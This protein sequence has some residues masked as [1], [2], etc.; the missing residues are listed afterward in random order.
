MIGVTLTR[1]ALGVFGGLMFAAG[2]ALAFTG[3]PDTFL[4]AAF[5]LVGGATL[6]LVAVLEVNRYRSEA[7][8]SGRLPSPPSG[9]EPALPEPRFQRT[10]EVFVDPTTHRR[11]RVFSDPRTGE[12]RYVIES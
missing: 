11:M 3:G 8:D 10:E 2:L 12:R 4:A 5:M 7:A 1:A 9:G 6:V